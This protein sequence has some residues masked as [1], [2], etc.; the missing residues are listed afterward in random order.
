MN[1]LRVTMAAVPVLAPADAD[2]PSDLIH[3]QIGNGRPEDVVQAAAGGFK[4]QH[5]Y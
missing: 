4:A 5:S 3:N 2:L 1:V